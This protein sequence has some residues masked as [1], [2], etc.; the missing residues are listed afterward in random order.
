MIAEA[1]FIELA[2]TMQY[3]AR[4]EFEQGVGTFIAKKSAISIRH[5]VGE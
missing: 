3:R 5:A 4:V 2:I 1:P